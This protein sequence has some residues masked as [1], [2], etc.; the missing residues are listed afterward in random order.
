MKGMA[1]CSFNHL[2]GPPHAVSVH[3]LIPP[4]LPG[5]KNDGTPV[6]TD[7]R[8]RELEFGG[9]KSFEQAL[10]DTEEDLCEDFHG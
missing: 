2:S 10:Y 1:C 9:M 8:Y 4:K 6:S 3:G 7:V 5:V